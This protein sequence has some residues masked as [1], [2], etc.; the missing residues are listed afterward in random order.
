MTTVGNQLF[1]LTPILAL[2]VV[3]A[4]SIVLFLFASENLSYFLSI[5]NLP[6]IP[7][8]PISSSQAL[9]GAI[10]GVGFVKES[11]NI[12]S[13]ILGKIALGW[14]ITPIVAGILTYITLF[15]VQNVF[16]IEVVSQLH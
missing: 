2:I 13:N 16:E 1:K 14:V 9:I 12:N 5:L 15:F 4:E 8:V 7:L 3:L 11:K 6:S 10:L